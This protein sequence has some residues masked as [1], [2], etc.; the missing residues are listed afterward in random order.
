VTT[1]K[2]AV[3]EDRQDHYFVEQV[4]ARRTDLNALIND[5]WRLGWKLEHMTSVSWGAFIAQSSTWLVLV[6]A[7]RRTKALGGS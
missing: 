4:S 5:R 6:W 1:A 3:T 2:D 7:P